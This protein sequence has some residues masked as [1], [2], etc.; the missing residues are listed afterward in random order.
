MA[1]R[2]VKIE[3]LVSSQADGQTIA[4]AITS[5]IAGKSLFAQDA[6]IAVEQDE[7]GTWRVV[8][9]IRFNVLSDADAWLN[10]VKSKWTSGALKNKILA[11]SAVSIHNCN[12]DESEKNWISCSDSRANFMRTVK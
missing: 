11:G 9:S 6:P 12:H 5:A 8:A 3:L 4:S 10:D 2:R 1:K 7:N